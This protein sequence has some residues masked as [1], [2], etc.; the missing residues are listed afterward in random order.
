MT[1]L[2]I[3]IRWFTPNCNTIAALGNKYLVHASV[4]RFFSLNDKEGDYPTKH[5]FVNYFL[6]GVVSGVGH[7]SF[8]FCLQFIYSNIFFS[9][10]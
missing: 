5:P 3:F 10:N 6:A 7:T 8:L 2:T 9:P 4:N 1:Q